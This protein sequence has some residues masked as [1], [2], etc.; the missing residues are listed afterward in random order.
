MSSKPS[1]SLRRAIAHAHG[2]VLATT[3]DKDFAGFKG[4]TVEN[5]L[6]R[7]VRTKTETT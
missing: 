5:W 2:L 1:N 6:K 3:I 4:L 7:H